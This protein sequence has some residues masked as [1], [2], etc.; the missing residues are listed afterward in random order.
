[1]SIR[2]K[3]ITTK[4]FGIIML[5]NTLTQF[6][7][8]SNSMI[9]QLGSMKYPEVVEAV[10]GFRQIIENARAFH[11]NAA[12]EDDK[13]NE[14]AQEILQGF[15]DNL[16]E[17]TIISKELTKISAY[18]TVNW[19]GEDEM[20]L[21][22]IMARIMSIANILSVSGHEPQMISFFP[23][24]VQIQEAEQESKIALRV[25]GDFSSVQLPPELKFDE[26]SFNSETCDRNIIEFNIPSR[27]ILRA[28]RIPCSLTGQLILAYSSTSLPEQIIK[29]IF[30]ITLS[31]WP[32][33]PG[34]IIISKK[35]TIEQ[36]TSEERFLNVDMRAA[37][38][39]E[40]KFTIES[41][42][43]TIIEEGR[44]GDPNRL[45]AIGPRIYGGRE[46][47]D[48]PECQGECKPP[49]LE[50]IESCQTEDGRSFS[51]VTFRASL[52]S[53]VQPG[54]MRRLFC[55]APLLDPSSVRYHI[56]YTEKSLEENGDPLS[57][58][59]G[60]QSIHPGNFLNKTIEFISC[61]GESHLFTKSETTPFLR[62]TSQGDNF[63]VQPVTMEEGP[64]TFGSYADRMFLEGLEIRGDSTVDETPPLTVE[65]KFFPKVVFKGR[66][67]KFFAQWET[68]LKQ[69]EQQQLEGN[70]EKSIELYLASIE[71]ATRICNEQDET[72]ADY[73]ELMIRL[74]EVYFKLA[75]IEQKIGKSEEA[76]EHF[77]KAGVK[78]VVE[79]NREIIRRVA[80]LIHTPFECSPGWDL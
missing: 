14:V 26:A 69:A 54:R 39:F 73:Q 6:L 59:W 48:S 70:N 8:N 63:I 60:E 38:S 4:E 25:L 49:S 67:T 56:R 1:M 80:S 20:D 62:V 30:H 50:Q 71:E 64:D 40:D 61:L 68:H 52:E 11:A 31:C 44:P 24:N 58:R 12:M 35:V 16:G 32:S 43:G 21:N 75:E 17:L 76:E 66:L 55:C 15:Q 79:A 3:K 19:I 28:K 10:I 9:S 23:H 42:P 36:K 37:R 65:Q 5:E 33:S 2:R 34:K 46:H 51:R 45:R 53:P 29:A 22:D 57:L 7:K 78:G 18:R 74:E 13:V 77:K 72:T 41:T 27:V 47:M